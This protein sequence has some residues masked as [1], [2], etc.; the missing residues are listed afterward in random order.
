MKRR[1][2]EK[3]TMLY[4]IFTITGKELKEIFVRRGSMRAGITNLLLVV[5]VGGVMFPFQYGK[6]WITSLIGLIMV[7]W[8][9]VMM[10]M[11]IVA[12]SFAGERERHTLETLLAS[13]LSDQAI[14][15]G[16]MLASVT[17]G[18]SIVLAGMLLGALTV[19]LQF[20]G[21]GFYPMNHFLGALVFSLLVLLLV[22]CIGVQV[23]L[24]AS[25]VR[26]AAQAM[27][28]GFL[29]IWLPLMLL[30]Q[31]MPESW[32]VQAAA[33]L[34]NVNGLQAILFLG[35]A[36]LLANLA[37]VVLANARFRRARLILD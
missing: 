32:K 36:L 14:L 22:T 5:V 27:S 9:P 12:D 16:K 37:L 24:H 34:A 25:T 18:M 23:S 4:D 1:D 30:P 17:Y 8:L 6:E 35:A 19:N 2:Q 7:S 33:W 13:R 26:Q 11:G 10:S 3:E 21:I 28:L 15:Y 31:Y 20:P 29:L